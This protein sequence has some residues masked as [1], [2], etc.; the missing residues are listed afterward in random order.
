MSSSEDYETTG[1]GLRHK[2]QAQ[3]L[4]KKF[5]FYFQHR[6]LKKTKLFGL[7]K[8]PT[9]LDLEKISYSTTS[10]FGERLTS[11]FENKTSG[12]VEKNFVTFLKE[13]R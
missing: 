4:G 7:R 3:D 11:D 6:T 8:N 13:K 2:R 10:D 9:F 12:L 5:T 1:V